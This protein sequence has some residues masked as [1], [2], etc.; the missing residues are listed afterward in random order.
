M[1]ANLL[2]ISYGVYTARWRLW[3]NVHQ[4]V[5]RLYLYKHNLM[6]AYDF[7][8]GMHKLFWNV[9]LRQISIHI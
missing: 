7:Q 2:N 6:T 3:K 8:Y 5:T 1:M 9:C 4:R